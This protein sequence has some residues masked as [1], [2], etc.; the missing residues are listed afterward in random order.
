MA[1]SFAL[2]LA[3]LVIACCA[4]SAARAAPAVPKTALVVETLFILVGSDFRRAE[5]ETLVIRPPGPG[6][7]PL[8]VIAHGD[9]SPLGERED[10]PL[11]Q[12][13][14]VTE[15]FARRGYAAVFA[16]RTGHG[17]RS[18]GDHYGLLTRCGLG[19]EKL[20]ALAVA[21]YIRGTIEAARK[22]PFVDPSRLIV[23]GEALGGYGAIALS[24]DPP[25]GLAI[26]INFAGGLRYRNLQCEQSLVADAFG[27]FG[28]SA[29]TPAL[30][31]Y[32][33]NDSHFPPHVA[34]QF[35]KAFAGAG[36]PVDYRALPEHGADGHNFF[37]DG[38]AHWRTLVD[39]FLAA[40]GLPNWDA[41]PS[42]LAL[43]PALAM[44]ASLATDSQK[45]GW[46]RFLEG[47][48]HR[49]F[50]VHA[51]SGPNW[52]YATGRP[53]PAAARNA[54]LATCEKGGA[55]CRIIALD[56]QSTD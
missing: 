17:G 1:R 29:R 47:A 9:I 40:H 54:A 8:A 51:E 34:A 15:E 48:A 27:E 10:M 52:G 30:W 36:A 50:A 24:A 23:I 7:F 3:V 22:F 37:Q 46:P 49:A 44:P 4:F 32:T 13:R 18:R 12:Y 56:D 14:A 39:G 43:L 45:A 5:L 6:P 20:F 38:I 35:H 16:L 11:D 42:D 25:S 26:T 19:R 28:R 2:A 33:A 31:L 53:S 41:P 55:P 21:R